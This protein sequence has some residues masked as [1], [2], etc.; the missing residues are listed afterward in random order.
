M[1]R[2]S[3]WR[4]K[5]LRGDELAVGTSGRTSAPGDVGH[6]HLLTV[7]CDPLGVHRA[8]HVEPELRFVVE[9]PVDL[10]GVAR[11]HRH[12]HAT[13]ALAH[14]G[15]FRE[16][17]WIAAGEGER[18]HVRGVELPRNVER[19]RRHADLGVAVIHV[20]QDRADGQDERSDAENTSAHDGPLG[21]SCS[22]IIAKISQKVK[23]YW[24]I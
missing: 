18:G 7:D 3:L 12:R 8:Q 23:L 2:R 15:T 5:W 13:L 1:A 16:P 6:S 19:R 10:D 20:V 11:R 17:V 4:K 14:I 24:L 21:L 9:E 22:T